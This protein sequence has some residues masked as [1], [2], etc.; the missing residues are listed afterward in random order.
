MLKSIINPNLSGKRFSLIL[1]MMLI[2]LLA[3]STGLMAQTSTPPSNYATSSGLSGDPYFISS[4]DNLYWLSQ[5]SGDWDKYY[6]QTADIDATSTNTWHSGAGFSPIG[7][8]TTQFTGNYNG[9]GHTIDALF[10]NRG[11]T[12]EIGLFGESYEATFSNI[13]LINVDITGQHSTGSIVGKSGILFMSN[14]YSTGSINGQ[15]LVGGMTGYSCYHTAISHISDN[16]SN[17]TV[18]GNHCVGGF[19]GWASHSSPV[20]RCYSTGLVTAP[21]SPG[22]LIACIGSTTVN[23]S[24]WDTQTSGQS[25]S[26]GGTGKTTAQMKTSTT[27]TDASWDFTII[28][29]WKIDGTNNDGYPYLG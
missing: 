6:E 5:T 8:S 10:I 18:T 7:N 24:F 14:C 27:F 9:Q 23:N 3:M 13:G 26:A 20:N 12:D 28:P 1:G 17:C 25:S 21:S 11:T 4:L 2:M 16:Y 22:G 19:I 15:D 29:I